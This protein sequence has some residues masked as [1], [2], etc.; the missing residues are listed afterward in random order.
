MMAYDIGKRQ[1]LLLCYLLLEQLNIW[2]RHRQGVGHHSTLPQASIR[3][4][5]GVLELGLYNEDTFGLG[6]NRQSRDPYTCKA[7]MQIW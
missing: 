6:E 1:G 3:K 4:V 2:D 7:C 5:P